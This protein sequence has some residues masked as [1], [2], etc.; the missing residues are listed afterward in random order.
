[1][2]HPLTYASCTLA[3][4]AGLGLSGCKKEQPPQSPPA[5][6]TFAPPVNPPQTQSSGTTRT[7]L[8][9]LPATTAP[10]PVKPSTLHPT[11]G[12]SGQPATRSSTA[13][14][15]A[16][17]RPPENPKIAEF[18]GL[19]APKPVT[20]L[21]HPPA[22]SMILNEYVVPGQGESDQAHLK[23][24]KAGGTVEA[25]IDRWKGQFRGPGGTAVEPKI[26]KL[27]ADGIPITVVE[28]DGEYKGM[29]A[30]SFSPDQIMISAIVE[31]PTG[32]FFL[33][34]VGPAATVEPNRQAFMEMIRGIRR[35][36]PEK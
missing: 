9:P 22:N 5:R 8:T 32:Q 36:E 18:A 35:T 26:E 25:N 15:P 13:L 3:L 29:G 19:T 31:A 28:L 33:T 10:M 4:A 2:R 14:P 6:P 20:W 34:L 11:T 27:D 24:V 30:V 23:I 1:M 12:L 21:W 16:G 17:L 7:P